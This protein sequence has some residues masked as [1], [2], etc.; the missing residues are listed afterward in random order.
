MWNADPLSTLPY[1]NV[2]NIL[3]STCSNFYSPRVVGDLERDVFE[4]FIILGHDP[5]S[6]A[7][8]YVVYTARERLISVF[9]R[10][11]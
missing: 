2:D 4:I 11:L 10:F 6:I 8:E 5:W 1:S 9:T 7:G 3:A